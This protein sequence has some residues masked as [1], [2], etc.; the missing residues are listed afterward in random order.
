ML[1]QPLRYVGYGNVGRFFFREA[2]DACRD[3]A[4]GQ[5]LAAFGGGQ[6]EA[7]PIARSQLALG[8]LRQS[9]PDD[10]SDGMQDVAAGQVVSRRDFRL[11]RR[12][13]MALGLHDS[14]TSF[15]QSHAGHSMDHIVDTRVERSKAAQELVIS[16]IDDG[17]D[18]QRRNISLPEMQMLMARNGRQI[19]AIGNPFF[20][21]Q[22]LEDSR[23]G[24]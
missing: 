10:R 16:G 14:K 7:A 20:P 11:A 12:L 22:S 5:G 23:F 19:A 18:S 2:E 24:S 13:S 8:L 6:V 21:R 1:P 4:E 3:A 17:I 9:T 15:P